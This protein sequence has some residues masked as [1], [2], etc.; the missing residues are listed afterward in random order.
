MIFELK[1]VNWWKKNSVLNFEV[2]VDKIKG[3]G[4]KKI[5]TRDSWVRD[6]CHNHCATRPC[7][8]S[9]FYWKIWFKIQ[10]FYSFMSQKAQKRKSTWFVAKKCTWQCKILSMLRVAAQTDILDFNL[11]YFPSLFCYLEQRTVRNSR[12]PFPSMFSLM[13]WQVFVTQISQ[14]FAIISDGS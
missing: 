11:K 12:G 7:L 13:K 2:W 14:I 10:S 6:A 3:F 8:F 5:W 9:L 4:S 1:K